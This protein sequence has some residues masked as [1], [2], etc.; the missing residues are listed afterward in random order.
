MDTPFAATLRRAAFAAQRCRRANTAAGQPRRDAAAAT[1]CPA[2]ICGCCHKRAGQC[3]S[4]LLAN[5]DGW[6]KSVKPAHARQPVQ[7]TC[8]KGVAGR[9]HNINNNLGRS[10]RRGGADGQRVWQRGVLILQQLGIV[11]AGA[12]AAAVESHYL[13]FARLFAAQRN[14]LL[15]AA[16]EGAGCP[17]GSAHRALHRRRSALCRALWAEARGF[18]TQS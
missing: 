10:K 8:G 13:T 16:W 11:P 3:P 7:H 1:S 17:T 15:R 6:R 14:A 9:S 18:L 5:I 12:G 4:S 2:Y